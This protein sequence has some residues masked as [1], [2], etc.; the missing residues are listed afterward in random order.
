MKNSEVNYFNKSLGENNLLIY[1][2]YWFLSTIYNFVGQK[3]H[4]Q[5]T[6]F[7]SI[8]STIYDENNGQIYNLS[9]P[10]SNPSVKKEEK[11]QK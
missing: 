1:T 6:C 2:F 10:P 5:S 4:P 11:Y 9:P 3:Y 8:W 7:I